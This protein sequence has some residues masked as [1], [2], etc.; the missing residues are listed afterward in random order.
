M[1][2]IKKI[3]TVSIILIG[4]FPQIYG[5]EQ[6]AI[7]S[8]DINRIIYSITQPGESFMPPLNALF[9]PKKYIEQE[10]IHHEIARAKDYTITD[11]ANKLSSFYYVVDL[12]GDGNCGYRSILTSLY[13]QNIENPHICEHLISLVDHDFFKIFYRYNTIFDHRHYQKMLYVQQLKQYL[14]VTLEDIAKLSTREEIFEY[15]KNDYIFDYG[16]IMFIRYL[17]ID[18]I[19][20]NMPTLLADGSMDEDLLNEQK[21][22]L[23]NWGTLL[24]QITTNIVSKSLPIV[25]TTITRSQRLPNQLLI[26][27]AQSFAHSYILFLGGHYE[28]LI[29][30]TPEILELLL[31]TPTSMDE[32]S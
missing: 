19:N 22:L 5:S 32:L 8:A 27:F 30:N 29:P 25:I 11:L 2:L 23:L 17:A 4:S 20:E 13:M 21:G 15:L 14:L 18:Y 9:T 26:P 12:R 1:K 24:E 6:D 3:I 16:M 31:T 28:A 7:I 10:Y